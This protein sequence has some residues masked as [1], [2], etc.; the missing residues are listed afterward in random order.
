V[1]PSI[2]GENASMYTAKDGRFDI[3]TFCGCVP[4]CPDIIVSFSKKGYKLLP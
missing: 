1:Y 4:D 2:A 3:G